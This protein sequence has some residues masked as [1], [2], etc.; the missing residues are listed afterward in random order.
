MGDRKKE[1]KKKS[2]SSIPDKLLV[3]DL[4]LTT[5]LKSDRISI[6]IIQGIHPTADLM[7]QQIHPIEY[8]GGID[9]IGF[10]AC[11]NPRIGGEFGMGKADPRLAGFCSI[12]LEKEN[13]ILWFLPDNKDKR[14][15]LN[16]I[17]E[18]GIE[19]LTCKDLDELYPGKGIFI[20]L[21]TDIGISEYQMGKDLNKKN[22]KEQGARYD[23]LDGKLNNNRII[24]GKSNSGIK[25]NN[26]RVNLYISIAD[27]A[28]AAKKIL[29]EAVQKGFQKIVEEINEWWMEKAQKI[30]IPDKATELEKEIARRM[31]LNLF[32][33]QD[34]NTGAIVASP[35]RQPHYNCDW[36]RDGAFY[37]CAL[38]F[39]GFHDIVDAHLQFYRKMQRRNKISLS[40]TW[41]L[42]F[43]FPLYNPLGHWYSNMWTQGKAGWF[44]MV[45]IEIDE[46]ALLVW[47]IW[48]HEKYL[49]E[50]SR[51]AEYKDQFRPVLDLAL[52]GIMRYVDIKKGWSKRVM[53]DDDFIAK[54]TLHGVS[55][56]FCALCAGYDLGTRWNLNEKKLNAIKTAA[57]YMRQGIL[58]RIEP[59]QIEQI[60]W[61]GLQWSLFPAPVFDKSFSDQ[62]AEII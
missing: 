58:K 11:F 5:S 1:N 60:G 26:D 21:T 53:E 36:P 61:R 57:R 24:F 46:T 31:I 19:Q 50:D 23:F 43:K 32:I 15:L 9:W 20:A 12:F 18:Y 7:V 27:H 17:K 52:D 10:Y 4:A 8:S 41:L 49:V 2:F 28:E 45:P 47:D 51:K 44:K 56:I 3:S 54:S 13:C 38:D 40:L 39:A 25:L 48:R 22:C 62:K 55:A 14:V 16:W 30:S 35:S 34:K 6:K 37:D 29:K 59:K 33:G 42:S